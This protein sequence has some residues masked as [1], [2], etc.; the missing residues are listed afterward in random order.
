MQFSASKNKIL[1]SI[2]YLLVYIAE[3]IYNPV[4]LLLRTMIVQSFSFCPPKK[5]VSMQRFHSFSGLEG[6]PIQT[7]TLFHYFSPKASLVKAKSAPVNQQ[8]VEGNVESDGGAPIDDA[9]MKAGSKKRRKNGEE[10]PKNLT[11]RFGHQLIFICFLF[12]QILLICLEG[13]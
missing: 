1:K 10:T 9:D 12:V 4:L 6:A 11:S 5:C 8:K 2:C 13:K 7:R 3:Y